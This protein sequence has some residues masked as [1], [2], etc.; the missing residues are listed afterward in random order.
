MEFDWKVLAAATNATAISAAIAV[1]VN[2]FCKVPVI[3]ILFANA[4]VV[5]VAIAELP[6]L[7]QALLLP[8]PLPSYGGLLQS[9]SVAITAFAN[10][11]ALSW[12]CQHFGCLQKVNFE[13]MSMCHPDMSARHGRHVANVTTFDGFF[14]YHMLCHVVDCQHVSNATTSQHGR[15][16]TREAAVQ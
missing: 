2:I 4:N 6:L 11:T 14:S 13:D 15:G 9:S 16:A 3:P 5:T 1:G 12:K 10:T 8:L 7:L